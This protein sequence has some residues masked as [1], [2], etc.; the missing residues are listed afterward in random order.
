[1]SSNSNNA[2]FRIENCTA[3]QEEIRLPINIKPT[4]KIECPICKK[5]FSLAE[6]DGPPVATV[7]EDEEDSDQ[8]NDDL[9]V[10]H[11]DRIV[12]EKSGED[13]WEATS[14]PSYEKTTARGRGKTQEGFAPVNT[15]QPSTRSKSRLKSEKRRKENIKGNK[16]KDFLKVI[17]GGILAIPVSQLVLW[18]LFSTDP[19]SVA[20]SVSKFAPFVVPAKLRPV[21]E[22]DE[23]ERPALQPKGDP[24]APGSMRVIRNDQ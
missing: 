14:V 10:P 24:D 16:K 18:W 8:S 9:S 12:V 1:M 17:I 2:E 6:I 15:D 23:N 4:A 5:R 3:C 21:E 7:I 19:L 13:V 20:P 11:V 22:E